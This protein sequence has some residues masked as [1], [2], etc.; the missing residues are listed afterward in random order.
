M[1]RLRDL[2]TWG[3]GPGGRLFMKK[4]MLR[5]KVYF[6]GITMVCVC[7]CTYE[8]GNGSGKEGGDGRR[9]QVEGDVEGSIK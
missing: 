9:N 7:V 4:S 6:R 8:F 2:P 5:S 3:V 1:T